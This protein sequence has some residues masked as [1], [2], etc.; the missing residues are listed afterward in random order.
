MIGSSLPLTPTPRVHFQIPLVTHGQH[1]Q[2]DVSDGTPAV[3]SFADVQWVFHD[4]GESFARTR[5]HLPP[6]KTQDLIRYPRPTQSQ[7]QRGGT[8]VRQK[9][10]PEALKRISELE[11]E[12]LKL[13]AQIA[14]IVTAAPSS[15]LTESQNPPG[16][17][18][19]SHPPVPTLTST[20]RC[21]PPPPPPPPP[22]CTNSSTEN[23]SVL[24]LIRQ[25]QN[26][27]TGSDQ[28]QPQQSQLNRAAN[29]K[30]IPSMLDV[31]KELNQ[32]KLRSVQR[33]PGGTVVRRRSKG[34]AAL[35]SDPA[36]LIA[37]ALKRKF[38]Q[39]RH[40]NS[41]DKENSAELSPFGSPETPQ[42]SLHKR[43]SLGRRHF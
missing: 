36:A 21:A 28:L 34:G 41:S 29:N 4:Q 24:E 2:V 25:R 43:R 12:L 5:N 27:E 26:K 3:P 15:G 22:P 9:M 37:E 33:S 20:P 1:G 19:M 39:N 16:S 18:L 40:N 8:A 31:L 32:V 23:S 11:S 30:Q 14:M 35:L 10:N 6:K 17:P 7:A 13:R 38:A 42:V